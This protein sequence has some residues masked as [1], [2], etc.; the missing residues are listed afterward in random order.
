M[1][2]RSLMLVPSLACQAGCAYCFG[3]NRG[4]VMSSN[5]FDATLDWIE[6]L[7]PAGERID[8]TF[9]GG[10]PLL[11]GQQWYRR[12]LPL[13]RARLGDRLRLSLQSNLW[14]LD[15]ACCGL[16]KEHGV[17]L[18]TSLDGPPQINDRQRG[19]GYFERTMVGIET[20]RRNGL[21]VGAICTF[22]RLSA[23]HYREVLEFFAAEHLSLSIHAAIPALP[24][25]AA[26]GNETLSLPPDVHAGLFVRIFD[27]YMDHVTR[28]QIST[29]DAMARS[30][31]SG[32]SGLCTFGNCLGHYLTAGPEETIY[33]CNR[34]LAHP[35]WAL[36]SVLERPDLQAL[37][38][39]PAWQRLSARQSAVAEDCGDCLHWSYC[40][41]G[42]AYNA[43]AGGNGDRRDPHCAAYRRL[44]DRI[45]E[46]AMAEVFAEENLDAIV[47][48]GPGRHGLL[49][50]GRLLQIMRDGPHP[51]QV[52]GRARELAAAVALAD[53]A[54]PEEA[55]HK[56]DRAGLIT[57]PELA[58]NSLSG[59]RGRLD[60]QPRRGLANAYLHVTYT[61]NLRCTHCYACAGPESLSPAM[62]VDDAAQL[63]GEAARAGFGK[64]VITGGEPLLHPHADALLDAL[65]SLRSEVKPL[66]IVLRTNLT[67]ALAPASIERLLGS[68]DQIVVSVDGDETAHDARRGASAYARTVAHLRLL[69]QAL[70][71]SDN[72]QGL[73]ALGIAAVLAAGQIDGPAGDAV[74]ALG[75]ELGLPVR[76]KSVLPL[77]RGAG[78]APA[79]AFYSSLDDDVEVIACSARPAAT[80]GLGMNLYVAPDGECYPCYAL[81]GSRHRLGNALEGLAAVLEQNDRYR[82]VTVDSNHRCRRCALRYVCGGFCR[83]WGSGG[84]PDGPPGDCAVL[85]ERARCLLL[86]ALHVLD[87]PAERWLAAGLPLP[88]APPEITMGVDFS[89]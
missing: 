50:K 12:N 57:R 29:L 16:F 32:R 67:C 21:S 28:M 64:A 45:T 13:L 33:P 26:R 53:S 84:D 19:A 85:H 18:G 73:A 20:A 52:A 43:L 14:L 68:V 42:C 78:L 74:R 59:L 89:L 22:T 47:A 72:P 35:E 17:S 39:S 41:G 5:V 23:P 51:Q 69:T 65:A 88:D 75:K 37:S 48:Q 66:Q 25:P 8:L 63:V 80:C 49:H 31:S 10:E 77:G 54:S 60:A 81:A 1:T 40:R 30:V 2:S 3:P 62:A 86:S 82:S 9:H 58:L 61:C 4:P 34:F 70:E 7:V 76:F 71:V 24:S 79:P 36:G 44:F 15:D 27:Y 46:R 38:H 55:L 87:V 83:A 56:L 6:A 11:A